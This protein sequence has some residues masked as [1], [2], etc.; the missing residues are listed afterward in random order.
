MS[1]KGLTD[2]NSINPAYRMIG[3][4]RKGA[5]KI[6]TTKPGEE[7]P[8]WRFTSDV[9]EI[10]QAFVEAYGADPVDLEVYIPHANPDAAF[11]TWCEIWG[12]TGLV[13]RC[14]GATMQVWLEGDHYVRGEKPCNG[15]H[16][17][18][19]PMNDAVGR[20][21]VILPKLIQ[22]GHVGTVVMETHSRHDLMNITKV[23]HKVFNDRRSPEG[24][25]GIPFTLSRLERTISVPGYGNQAGKRST[26][27]KY[28]ATLTP[29]ASWVA[30]NMAAMIEAADSA[31][32]LTAGDEGE[33][34]DAD[35]VQ[36]MHDDMATWLSG[37]YAIADQAP[38]E[39]L[40][41]MLWPDKW[42]TVLTALQETQKYNNPDKAHAYLVE[43][44]K[45]LMQ[46][47]AD[48]V[49]APGKLIAHVDKAWPGLSDLYYETV[50]AFGRRTH[51]INMI[52]AFSDLYVIMDNDPTL[53]DNRDAMSSV[54]LDK[55]CEAEGEEF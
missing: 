40:A 28:L 23:L 52:K 8:H 47:Y 27:T 5:E 53:K 44:Y 3:K 24:L 11:P 35:P 13:H 37:E 41:E 43:K 51:P 6:S 21:E 49:T 29:A 46:E 31:P 36:E 54:L 10:E 12:A 1:I 14:D 45:D 26:A 2:S 22:A 7:L 55:L 25:R 20:L 4:L 19:E 30:A 39:T 15:G 48:G 34:I 33:I 17:K 38:T 50:A 42:E 16:S 18:G 32:M 9:P